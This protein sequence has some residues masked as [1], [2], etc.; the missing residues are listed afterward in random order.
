[1]KKLS[2]S[3]VDSLLGLHSTRDHPLDI[4]GYGFTTEG[5]SRFRVERPDFLPQIVEH[6][7]SILRSAGEFPS[8]LEVESGNEQAF[9][10]GEG[11][12]FFVSSMEEVSLGCFKRIHAGP[13]SETDAIRTYLQKMLNADYFCNLG[14]IE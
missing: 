5:A 10:R 2:V 4:F 13:M 12:W 8:G 1:M 6:V 14:L 7:R 11:E 3:E 9:V